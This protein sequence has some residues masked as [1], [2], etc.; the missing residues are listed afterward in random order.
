MNAI[1][2]AS[3]LMAPLLRRAQVSSCSFK[4]LPQAIICANKLFMQGF[5]AQIITRDKNYFLVVTSEVARTMYGR[6]FHSIYGH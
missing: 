2:D 6:G 4:S 5:N 3:A 1:K